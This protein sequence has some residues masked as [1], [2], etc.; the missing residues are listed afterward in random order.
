[1]HRRHLLCSLFLLAFVVLATGG[2][3]GSSVQTPIPDPGGPFHTNVAGNRTLGS[4]TVDEVAQLC[5]DL[6][7]ADR[8]F[9]TT[10][11]VYQETCLEFGYEAA[12]AV[13]AG[14][15]PIDSGGPEAADAGTGPVDGGSPDANVYQ[16]VCQREYDHCL[17]QQ[18]GSVGLSCPLPVP[19]CSATVEL[20]SACL[21][22]IAAADPISLC[23]GNQGCGAASAIE[24]VLP[25]P[26]KIADLPS[27]PA[28]DRLQ[29]ECSTVFF[30]F[31][32]ASP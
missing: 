27:T 12:F 18:T 31:P 19:G 17:S 15:A 21:N 11:A 10:A 6:Q 30:P 13:D 28:C 20:A 25:T 8:A 26:P 24:P 1:M 7:S 16:R 2:G 29:K 32:C 22:E 23:T 3:C 14:T 4:L 5:N 9:L